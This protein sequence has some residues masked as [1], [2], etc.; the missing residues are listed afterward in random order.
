MKEVHLQMET[1]QR[2]WQAGR[3]VAELV[4]GEAEGG[5]SL[6]AMEGIRGKTRVAQLVVVEVHGPEGSQTPAT[7]LSLSSPQPPTPTL[8]CSSGLPSLCVCVCDCVVPQSIQGP[9]SQRPQGRLVTHLRP[10][11]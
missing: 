5:D 7:S 4:V 1:L 8:H 9:V 2:G 3:Q 6:G 10:L 11:W